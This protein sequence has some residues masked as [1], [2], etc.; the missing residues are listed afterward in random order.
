MSVKSTVLGICILAAGAASAMAPTAVYKTANGWDYIFTFEAPRWV[1]RVILTEKGNSAGKWELKECDLWKFCEGD[2][3]GA[4]CERD[5]WKTPFAHSFTLSVTAKTQPVLDA[6]FT[7]V[8]GIDKV[9]PWEHLTAETWEQKLKRLEW[10]TESRFGMFIHFGLY[11]AAGRHEWAK[12]NERISDADYQHYFDTFNPDRFDA[13]EWAK[14]AKAAGMKYVVL[15]A[16]HH[17]GF[18]LWDSDVTDYKITNTSFKRDLIK[19]YVEA[20]RA[21][22]LKV[23]FY[24]S[25]LDWHHPDFTIDRIHP[26]RTVAKIDGADAEAA[27]YAEVNKGRDMARY[28]QYMKDQVTEL[29]TR[30]GQIDIIWFDFSYPGKNGKGRDDWDSKGLLALARK[31]QP[32]IM[33]D[34]RLDLP[35]Y[36]DGWDFATPEQ[37]REPFWPKVNGREVPWETCQTFSGSWGY[38]RDEKTWKSS[39]QIIEQLLD[40]VSKGGNL[41]MNVGPT[42]AGEFDYRAKERLADYGKWLHENGDAIYGCTRAPAEFAAPPNTILTYN[43]KTKKLYMAVLSWTYGQIK[44][45]FA[46]RVTYAQLLNDKSQVLLRHGMLEIPTDKPPTEIPVIEFTLKY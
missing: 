38:S 2:A 6:E 7:R 1:N 36:E 18:C 5:F 30:Y 19:E 39:F 17:E 43:P 35:E 21:E 3:I 26:R 25:L 29:L 40:T 45:P 34:N 16:K 24:Y 31:L 9:K 10:W 4:R 8:E 12:S 41:L 33:V 13:R 14:A 15:T 42:G 37:N 28:R 46:G 27:D 11:A 22:G 32:G 44:L 23:G 20:F